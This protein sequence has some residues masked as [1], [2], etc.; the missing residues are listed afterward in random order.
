MRSRSAAALQAASLRN[1]SD[2]R[3][4]AASARPGAG[5]SPG[6]GHAD[7][8]DRVLHGADSRPSPSSPPLLPPSAP[9]GARES[10]SIDGGMLALYINCAVAG[11]AALLLL[12]VA[13]VIFVTRCSK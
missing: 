7:A 3:A 9:F 1:A 13:L 10:G 11:C 8:L 4:A 2:Q 5:R 6:T 12:L